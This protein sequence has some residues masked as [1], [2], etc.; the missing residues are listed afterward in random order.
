MKEESQGRVIRILSSNE[1]LI[2]IGINQG[3][4]EGQLFEIYE[5]GE[6]IFDPTTRKSLGTLDYIK[7]EVE[8]VTLYENFSSVQSRDHYT[9]KVTSGVMS[10]FAD[11]TR[12]VHKI[13]VHTLPVSEAEIKERIIHNPE[14][15]VG[16]LV[17]PVK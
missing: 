10:A 14:I 13:R 1:L 6:E 9:E 8:I 16:D 12:E 7:A 2:N 3:A 4:K 11:K 15:I 5:V 17:K